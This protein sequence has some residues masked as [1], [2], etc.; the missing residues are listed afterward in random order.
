MGVIKRQGIKHSIVNYVSV[1]AGAL[2]IFFIYSHHETVYGLGL[3]IINTAMFIVP[4]AT[5]GTATLI[6]RFFPFFKNKTNRHNGF[7]PFMWLLLTLS[8][9][10]FI[11]GGYVLKEP[12]LLLL[13]SLD[14]DVP[15]IRKYRLYIGLLCYI[16]LLMYLFNLYASNFNRI[17]VPAI[18]TNLI[19]KICL[20]I[21]VLLYAHQIVN[22]EIF[23][24]G[25]LFYYVIIVFCL[26]LYIIYLKEWTF[27]LKLSILTKKMFNDMRI[28]ASYNLLGAIGSVLAFRIDNIMVPT[29]IGLS[30]G[31]IYGISQFIANTIDIPARSIYAISAPIISDSID[32]NDWANVQEIYEKSSLNLLL[33]SIL[34]FL[35]IWLSIENLFT[36]IGRYS[37]LVEGIYVVFFIGLSKVIDMAFGINNH[38]IIY[39]KYFRFN[40]FATL[41]L[42]LLNIILNY[43]FLINYDMGI[44]GAALATLISVVFFNIVKFLFIKWK[45][46]MQPFSIKTFYLLIIGSL[47]Y[48]VAFIIPEVDIPIIDI[49]IKC[50]VICIIYIPAVLYFRISEDVNQ[51]AGQIIDKVRKGT[52]FKLK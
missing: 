14:F 24:S 17:T 23:M 34:F 18:Y 2:G 27:K 25:I 46:N 12:V 4:F 7:L 52:I 5:F 29:L 31:G 41:F 16:L 10:V 11:L 33:P 30:S 39:S 15:L 44:K 8:F 49:I 13:N 3:F 43:I 40:L 38:I 35:C 6:V 9:I 37:V 26:I 1:L 32:K 22:Q 48:V 20:P 19:P 36:L 45:F 21:L 47:T 42:G 28:Y 51:T 50:S